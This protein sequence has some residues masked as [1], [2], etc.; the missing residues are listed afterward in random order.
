MN[1][2]YSLDELR[3][4]PIEH[5]ME[6]L[7]CRELAEIAGCGKTEANRAIRGERELEPWEVRNVRDWLEGWV[8]GLGIGGENGATA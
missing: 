1:A 8:E 3:Y 5:V 6:C 7:S 2:I 4:R